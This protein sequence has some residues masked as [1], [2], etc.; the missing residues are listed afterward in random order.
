[1]TK[2]L[3]ERS[4]WI[5]F[6]IAIVLATAGGAMALTSSSS[7]NPRPTN[8]QVPVAS[9]AVRAGTDSAKT[10][11]ALRT[12]RVFARV[13][14]SVDVLTP[15]ALAAA[16]SLTRGQASAA[17]ATQLGTLGVG[18][19]RRVLSNQGSTHVDVY[20][21]PNSKG[22]VCV[23]YSA[24]YGSDGC[25]GSFNADAPVSYALTDPDQVGA[26]YP[27]IVAGLAPSTVASIGVIVNG[28]E[29]PATLE[30]GAYFYE[31]GP[32]DSAAGVVAHYID[33]STAT[34]GIPQTHVIT[35]SVG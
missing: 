18:Q 25:F 9:A 33:G 4:F 5:G 17:P 12:L 3:R 34:V 27:A 32:S 35:T 26:G 29:Q 7:K 15:Y 21:F 14:T 24:I 30:N 31:P 28:K 8:R 2:Y 22:Q 13:R 10:S 1:M 23:V 11:R 16:N 6:A 20:V 19:S